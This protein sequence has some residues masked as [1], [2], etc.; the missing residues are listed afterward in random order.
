MNN[1]YYMNFNGNFTRYAEDEMGDGYLQ[2]LQ[3]C[4]PV[5]R[6]LTK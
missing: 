6:E 4:Y 3:L 1:K 2:S 5:C